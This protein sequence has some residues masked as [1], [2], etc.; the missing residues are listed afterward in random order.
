LL[1]SACMIVKLSTPLGIMMDGWMVSEIE[2]S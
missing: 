2:Q 1:G